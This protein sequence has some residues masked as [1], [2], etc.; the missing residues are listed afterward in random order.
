MG[1]QNT[2]PAA[3]S[4]SLQAMDKALAELESSRERWVRLPVAQK[5]ELL[6]RILKDLH[7]LAEEWS[8][9]C[10]DAKNVERGSYAHG[11]EWFTFSAL[12]KGVRMLRD[13]L[14][15]VAGGGPPPLPGPVKPCGEGQTSVRVF[16][17]S[18]Y[19]RIFYPGMTTEIWTEPGVDEAAVRAGQ[20][21]LYRGPA[22]KGKTVLV[23]GAGNV[24]ILGP[25]DILDKL[26]CDGAVVIYKTHPVTDYLTPLLERGYAA[27]IEGGFL[28]IVR[29]AAEEGAYLTSHDRVDE[30]HLTGSDRTYDAIVFGPGPEGRKRKQAAER[31]VTKPFACELGNLSPV[32]VVPGPWSEG[33]LAYQGEHLAGMLVFNAGFNCLTTRVIIQHAGWAHRQDLLR[34]VRRVLSNTPTRRAYYPGAQAI[35][36]AFVQAHPEAEGLGEADGSRLPWTLI[37]GLDPARRD[38]ICF[39]TEGFCSLFSETALEAEDV[40][41]FVDAAVR[42]ANERL[43]GT[44]TSTILVH[45]ASLKDPAIAQAVERAVRDLRYGTVGVN[46]WGAMNFATMA[47]TWGAFPGH[48]YDDIQSGQ[49]TVHNLLMI[50]RPQ[51]TVIRGPFRQWP[52]PPVFP[53]FRTLVPLARRLVHFEAAPSP[54]KLP[55]ILLAASRG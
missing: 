12:L 52:K 36:H 2:Q 44:L 45:P 20:A 10:A 48:P 23:L 34:E 27:L 35:H 9:A 1:D 29:G 24:S 11:E 55:G 8:D 19:D 15:A 49:G 47:G 37:S 18:L 32:I 14:R 53:S 30:I 7:P 50:P 42:F 46:V 39:T 17:Q 31:L 22:P 25:W 4:V 43:W 21:G 16:P 13:T 51:K 5:A 54:F 38:D 40:P 3:R 33:D 6:D 28:R 41:S 26:F